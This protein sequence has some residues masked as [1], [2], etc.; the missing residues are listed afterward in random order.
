MCDP[1][2]TSGSCKLHGTRASSLFLR[3]NTGHLTSAE[4]VENM[5]SSTIFTST[6][7]AG[8]VALRAEVCRALAGLAAPLWDSRIP[9]GPRQLASL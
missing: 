9:A 2:C 7:T 1:N 4:C 3:S 5:K 8:N 6:T